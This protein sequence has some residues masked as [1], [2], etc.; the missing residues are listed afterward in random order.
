VHVN[1]DSFLALPRAG[2]VGAYILLIVWFLGQKC[3]K[4]MSSSDCE[5]QTDIATRKCRRVGEQ[6][7]PTL[8][9][10]SFGDENQDHQNDED[11]GRRS[12]ATQ[13]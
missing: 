4:R 12:A 7:S 8:T 9:R 3:V 5:L 13:T 6:D 11:G 2:F 10:V 1:N